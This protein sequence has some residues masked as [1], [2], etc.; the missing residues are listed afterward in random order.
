MAALIAVPSS[1]R[2]QLL[3]LQKLRLEKQ[4]KEGG[5]KQL[6]E[7]RMR[8]E[9]GRARLEKDAVVVHVFDAD[10][11][12]QNFCIGILNKSRGKG[13]K[14]W[15]KYPVDNTEVLHNLAQKDYLNFWAFV[16]LTKSAAEVNDEVGQSQES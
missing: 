9:K 7:E 13:K 3:Q 16:K 10:T 5:T 1:R 8:N 2:P 15:V 14:F 4:Q 11:P 12:Q 6:R